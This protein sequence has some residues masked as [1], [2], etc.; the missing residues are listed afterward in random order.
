MDEPRIP[1][2]RPWLG[3]EEIDALRAVVESGVLSRGRQLEAFESGMAR[4]TGSAGGVGVNSGT[5]G[6][7]IAMEALGIGPGDE[8]IAP[9]FTFVG[10]INAIVR[11]GARPVLVDVDEH[12]LNIDPAAAE[13]AIGART[14]AVLVVHLFG[15][16]AAMDEL[17]GLSRKRGLFVIEDACEAIGARYRN[18]TVGSLGDAGVFG[19]YPNKPV[20]TGEGGMIVADD[21]EFL[22]RCRQLRNQGM[23]TV[24]GTRHPD[25]PGHSARLSEL[26]AAVGNVQLERLEDSLSRREAVAERYS[27]NLGEQPAL[28]LPAPPAAHES[29]AWFT[30]PLRLREGSREARDRL[31]ASM[32]AEGIDCG[33]Y[34]EPVH[35]LPYH[36]RQHDGRAL[37]VSEQA[38]D[39]SIALPLYPEL[40]YEQVD[41]ICRRLLQILSMTS[42]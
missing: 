12:T 17:L 8:V 27:R 29:I 19:F 6:L 10:T 25:L 42:G 7:Q 28:R 36:D 34:F 39:R 32:A 3:R 35:R 4:L 11:T 41:A 40:E 5:V 26:H 20:A 14:R 22:T 37:P 16:P 24:T 1:L 38:G 15:R 33:V 21:P 23:D 2:A 30:Y 13:A 31:I 18:R 9:A